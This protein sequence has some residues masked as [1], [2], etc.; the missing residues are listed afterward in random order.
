M[1][2][3]SRVEMFNNEGNLVLLGVLNH[4]LPTIQAI[5]LGGG[6]NHFF[7]SHPCERDHT[8]RTK[9]Y[10]QIDSLSKFIDTLGMVVCAG[11]SIRKSMTTDQGNFKTF[12]ED[13]G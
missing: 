11:W 12:F 8:G 6:I 13:S 5:F 4:F 3:V 7:D 10:C 1:G 9:L 2:I